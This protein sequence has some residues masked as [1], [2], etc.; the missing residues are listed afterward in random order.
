MRKLNCSP[1]EDA[2]IRYKKGDDTI[3]LPFAL[4]NGSKS[5]ALCQKFYAV[6]PK[7]LSDERKLLNP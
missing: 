5:S 6:N 3:A 1:V 2:Q 4:R 7:E